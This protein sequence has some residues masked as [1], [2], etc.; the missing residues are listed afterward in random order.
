MYINIYRN[1][2]IDD[3]ESCTSPGGVLWTRDGPGY[4]M[5]KYEWPRI[6][7][8]FLNLYFIN[9]MNHD[10]LN[11]LTPLLY[12]NCVCIQILIFKLTCIPTFEYLKFFYEILFFK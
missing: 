11:R 7:L 5:K 9:H 1:N 10:F 8:N 3:V 12:L 4:Q 6:F 2:D